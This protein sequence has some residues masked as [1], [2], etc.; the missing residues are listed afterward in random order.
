MRSGASLTSLALHPRKIRSGSW[1]SNGFMVPSGYD[2]QP[3]AV[4]QAG[5]RCGLI[6]LRTPKDHLLLGKEN[7][8]KLRD[9]WC[10][11]NAPDSKIRFDLA[12]ARFPEQGSPKEGARQRSA[13]KLRI[14][15]HKLECSRFIQTETTLLFTHVKGD[16][17]QSEG[18]T[19]CI[20]P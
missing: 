15:I 9:F 7:R 14:V 8:K 17:Q 20:E 10:H 12:P 3:V 6:V 19:R 13:G 5:E 1:H 11:L 16:R 2:E 18:L 4:S